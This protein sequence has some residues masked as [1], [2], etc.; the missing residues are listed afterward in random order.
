MIKKGSGPLEASELGAALAAVDA[1]PQQKVRQRKKLPPLELSTV[2]SRSSHASYLAQ[3]AKAGL[4]K[5][6]PAAAPVSPHVTGPDPGTRVW[7]TPCVY[8]ISKIDPVS[9]T[10]FVKIRIYL[11]WECNLHEIESVAYLAARALAEGEHTKLS[12]SELVELEDALDPLPVPSLY[13]QVGN[14]EVL[15][16]PVMRVYS[17]GSGAGQTSVMWN[18]MYGWTCHEN[19]ELHDFPFDRQDLCVSLKLISSLLWERYELVVHAV[20]FQRDAA[21]L[22]EWLLCEPMVEKITH[23]Q[24]AVKLQI[25]RVDTYWITNVVVVMSAISMA[26]VLAFACPV[27]EVG[28]RLSITLTL[29]LTSVA[30]KLLLA[31]SLPKVAYHTR[32]DYFLIMQLGSLLSC[33]FLC[34]APSLVAQWDDGETEETVKDLN[35]WLC[36][37]HAASLTIGICVWFMMNRCTKK[38]KPCTDLITP[39]SEPWYVFEFA[40]APFL[41]FD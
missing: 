19:F 41:A 40:R 22:Q 29:L 5:T 7:C 37:A 38:T 14:A 17:R 9:S 31:E 20:Q 6:K 25:Q 34:V 12:K 11:Q 35:W 15:D 18:A 33:S 21:E 24:S 36:G 39:T 8:G 10:F 26:S 28:D 27:H 30:F 4:F 13:N 1:Q 2:P 23:A 3:T 32:M 16:D